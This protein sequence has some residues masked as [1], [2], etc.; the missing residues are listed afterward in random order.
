LPEGLG[1]A[2]PA[3]LHISRPEC[4]R[5]DPFGSEEAKWLIP[6]VSVS[7]NLISDYEVYLPDLVYV[8]IFV[9]DSKKREPLSIIFECEWLNSL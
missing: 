8:C 5:R 6:D 1:Y 4:R 3:G 9:I 7:I 2:Y